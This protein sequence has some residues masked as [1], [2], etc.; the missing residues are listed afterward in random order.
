MTLTALRPTQETVDI[1][2]SLGGR[3]HGYFAMCR[4]PA[5]SDRTPSLSIR[6]GRKSILVH[7]FAGCSND[8]VLRE[9]GRG[10]PQTNTPM[11]DFRANNFRASALRLWEEGREVPNT[12]AEVYLRSRNLPSALR[13]IRFHRRCPFGRKP[14]TKYLPALLVALREGH[15]IKAIQRIVIRPDG[16]GHSGKFMLGHPA[17]SAWCPPFSGTTLAIAESLEDAAAYTNLT[18]VTCWSAFGA[19]RLP[20]IRLP[21]TIETLIIAEDNNKAGRLGARNAIAAH[22]REGLTIRRHP[23]KGYEDW[24]EANERAQA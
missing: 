16:L 7:C 20:L 22:A 18:G 21:D 2:A 23:P 13:D 1:V 14:D 5:H 9:I 3:W 4:C 17:G 15:A 11:P 6:Q 19:E 10:S 12:L 8:D 24:A